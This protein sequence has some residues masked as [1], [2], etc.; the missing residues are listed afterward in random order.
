[1]SD[2]RLHIALVGPAEP[3]ALEQHLYDLA[4]IPDGLGGVPVNELADGLLSLG[5]RVSIYTCSP[6]VSDTVT[7]G[8]ELLD[9]T[10]VPL[11]RSARARALDCFRQE[12]RDLERE[13]KK[14]SFDVVHAHWTYEFALAAIKSGKSPL[15]VTAHDSPFTI[16]RFMPDAYRLIR[17]AMA[18][19]VRF[20]IRDLTAVSPYLAHRWR[21][22]MLYRRPLSVIANIVPGM[23]PPTNPLCVRNRWVVLDV[24]TDSRLKNVRTLISAFAMIVKR[25]PQAE[26][27][28]VGPG[29]GPADAIADWAR[30]CGLDA[31]VTFVGSLD[32]GRIADEY[33][34]ASIL[35]HASLEEAQPLALLEA[36]DAG[37]VVIGGESSGGVPWTLF[38]GRAGILVDVS[39]A[40]AI[41][42]GIADAMAR[43]ERGYCLEPGLARAIEARHSRDAVTSAYVSV[44]RRLIAEAKTSQT[45]GSQ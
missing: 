20:A 17:I 18:I 36:L 13:L 11:R 23:P 45:R 25:Y 27:R 39:S 34:R 28:L 4:D 12:R 2:G 31:N 33:A 42:D 16:L 44:Y 3:R 40:S 10:V 8:G 7:L 5:H 9:I 6:A 22:Q 37:L 14:S 21:T 41:A 43:V 38:E 32:R 19:R 29:L 26:L 24:A 30:S 35:C 15:L 1:M